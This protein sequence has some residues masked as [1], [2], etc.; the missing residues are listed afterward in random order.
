MLDRL[1]ADSYRIAMC[2]IGSYYYTM[3]FCIIWG[4]VDIDSDSLFCVIDC[5]TCHTR[6][7]NCR[8]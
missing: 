4:F 5:K 7:H 6:G 8:L 3:M 2:D 1:N